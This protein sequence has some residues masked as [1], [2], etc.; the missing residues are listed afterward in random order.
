M[1]RRLVRDGVR[2]SDAPVFT[3]QA[4]KESALLA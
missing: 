4:R 2:S 1:R 3:V